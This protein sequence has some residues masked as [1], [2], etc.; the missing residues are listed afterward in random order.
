MPIAAILALSAASLAGAPVDLPLTFTQERVVKL[1]GAETIAGSPR[2]GLIFVTAQDG[3]FAI[4][5]RTA[6]WTPTLLQGGPAGR[7]TSVDILPD[8][9]SIALATLVPED[10][11]QPGRLLFFDVRSSLLLADLEVGFHP[12]AV[13]ISEDARHAVVANEGQPAI[14]PDGSIFDP[15]G[16]ISVVNLQGLRTTEQFASLEKGRIRTIEPDAD[17]LAWQLKKSTP[18]APVRIHPDNRETPVRDVEPEY[19][20]IVRDQAWVTLQEN[21]AL[22]RIDLRRGSWEELIPIPLLL[23]VLDASDR[24]GIRIN[25]GIHTLPMPDQ[26]GFALNGSQPTLYFAGEGDTRGELGEGAP[27]TDHARHA[28]LAQAGRTQGDE[29]L[30]RLKV[31]TITGDLDDDG[32]IERP[33]AI[34]SRALHRYDTQS[35]EW[36][37]TGDAIERLV[38]AQAPDF[39]NANS[40]DPTT[41]DAR[42]DDRGPEPEGVVVH[43]SPWRSAIFVALERPGAIVAFDTDLQPIGFVMS[44]ENDFTAPEGMAF[45][46]RFDSPFNDFTLA[47]AFEGSGHVVFYTVA[48]AED[49]ASD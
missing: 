7:V 12:D 41:I 24:D 25:D 27:L 31:C 9:E 39:F 46:D 10:A 22:A 8:N 13:S 49:Q 21:N 37:H 2:N 26:L 20:V 19:V 15:P 45:F 38:A 44:A 5:T 28:D 35:G 16:S 42:S 32:V 3:L 47:V 40:E 6:D 36:S 33:N 11:T 14:L 18:D 1:P 23:Q 34:G 4:N 30:A 48:W 29:Q 43:D 17:W